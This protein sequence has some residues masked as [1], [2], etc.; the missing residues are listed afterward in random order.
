MTDR[1]P[2][3][4]ALNAAMRCRPS[5]CVP[6]SLAARVVVKIPGMSMRLEF[7]RLAS[8]LSLLAVL[9][10]LPLYLPAQQ[11]SPKP[12]TFATLVEVMEA[13]EKVAD[14]VVVRWNQIAR[15]SG[16]LLPKPREFTDARELLLRG[17]AAR[18][19]GRPFRHIG[20]GWTHIDYVSSYDGK[21][22]RCLI[23]L[24]PPRGYIS[25]EKG[26]RDTNSPTVLPLMLYF[27]P[28]AEPYDTLRRNTLQLLD[29]RKTID[30]HQC[31][32][33]DD[34]RTRVYLDRDRD[35]IP[36]AFKSSR[37]GFVLL[38]G[39]IEYY[40]KQDAMRW[41]PKVFQV[42][43]HNEGQKGVPDRVRGD[44]VQTAIG[45]PLKESDFA[46]TFEPGTLVWDGRTGEEYRILSD[47]SK[48]PIKQRRR[49]Y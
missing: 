1:N 49:A 19:A 46:L 28:L 34:G 15:Y 17:A 47:G 27:R 26:S 2:T 25:E 39:S 11:P 14:S 45:A 30:G 23:G 8:C 10:A 32:A 29:E 35:F 6:N 42:T 5:P 13:R 36:I 3:L 43:L 44:S 48:E 24:K 7:K 9:A 22:S 4:Y 37:P 16:S 40:R 20:E 21:L 41:H 18:C 31:V 38:E 33:I 12:I